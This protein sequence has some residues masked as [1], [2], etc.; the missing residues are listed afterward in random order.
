MATGS[1]SALARHWQLDPAVV[2]LNHGSFGACPTVVLQAQRA[3]QDRMEAEPVRF[4][5]R[6]LADLAAQARQ[7]L[8]SLLGCEADDLVL[9]DN[10]TAA[11][12]TVV[13][14][15]TWRP[16]DELLVVDH[17]YNACRNAAE[18]ELA[19]FGATVNV[20]VLPFPNTT[21][22]AVVAAV[23]AAV[24]PRTKLVLLD[25]ITSPTG[26]VLP[27]EQLV[28]LLQ[29][30]GVDVLVDGAHAPGML[31]LQLDQLGAAYFTGN[32]HKWLCTP[33]GCAFLHVRR[34]RQHLLRPLS[35]SHGWNR[36]QPGDSPLRALFDWTGTSDPTAHLVLPQ[37]IAF[38]AGLLPGGLAALQAH[39]HAL[40][41]Q[42]RDLL[43]A[44][45]GTTPPAP[46][47]ML[48][49]LAAV[50]LPPLVVPPVPALAHEPLHP[51]QEYLW[52]HHQI[53]VPIIAFGDQLLVR[54][55]MQAYNSLAQVQRLADVLA[56]LR[57]DIGG[58]A[59]TQ[60]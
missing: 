40:A 33:K 48:G 22:D 17:V 21:P 43:C 4:M 52:Q 42:G 12:N 20:A 31:P 47:S 10:A 58:A 50:V 14:S 3:L 30:R 45:V 32:C 5:V 35:V 49:S 28:P 15:L 27:V 11:V 39:N 57:A 41:L 2:F 1:F 60:T 9:L 7:A 23:L 26:L 19:R 37:A 6:E 46:D 16:G 56:G 18:A 44:A 29:D 51:L 36:R 24:T 38:L 34:D 25:H 13:R 8:A 59:V 53:E 54:I 55:A